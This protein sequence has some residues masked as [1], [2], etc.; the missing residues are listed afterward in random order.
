[1]G[2][3]SASVA[4]VIGNN[5][6]MMKYLTGPSLRLRLAEMSI[7]GLGS[8][9]LAALVAGCS[10]SRRGEGLFGAAVGVPAPQ[11]PV[12]LTGSMA[13]L[14]TNADSF[15]AHLVL[16]GET[17]FQGPKVTEG[18]LL[19]QGGKLVF[20]PGK[21]SSGA[22]GSHAAT[23]AFIWDVAR[24]QGYVL[25][26]PLQG[27]API[28]SNREFTNMTVSAATV[29]AGPETIAGHPCQPADVTVVASDGSTTVLRAWRATDLKGLPL[30][31]ATVSDAMPLTLTLSKVR[32]E[33][34]PEDLF[35][36]PSGFTRYA[37]AEAM[38]NEM[39]TRQ[40]NLK[41]RPVYVP[42]QNE[43]T[44]DQEHRQPTRMQ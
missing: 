39:T 27:Y 15:Q 24:R 9:V 28:S 35:A 14:L 31:I 7:S 18:Q 19:S 32:L 20:A 44:Y 16:E 38:I 11:P 21:G 4:A 26:G 1:M 41:R 40:Q 13:L 37:S 17:S 5:M 10:H 42:D 43:P 2:L 25:N 3:L 34:V 33:N 29:S 36:P 22:K 8:L 12:F 30:R 23:S 6:R